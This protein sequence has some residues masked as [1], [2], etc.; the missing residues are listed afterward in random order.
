MQPAVPN[1]RQSRALVRL[2][3][4]LKC[5]FSA[6]QLKTEHKLSLKWH[7]KLCWDICHSCT[8][9]L[10]KA[11]RKVSRFLSSGLGIV[12]T[13]ISNKFLFHVEKKTDKTSLIRLYFARF[14]LLPMKRYQPLPVCKN[15]V[16]LLNW[17]EIL[18]ANWRGKI[19]INLNTSYVSQPG[20]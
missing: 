14:Y 17:A 7:E 18:A 11:I 5:S 8:G 20:M 4:G 12:L 10:L 2:C 13:A 15:F 6:L 19:K 9:M 16:Y 3:V 1:C